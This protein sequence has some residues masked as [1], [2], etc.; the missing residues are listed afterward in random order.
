MSSTRSSDPI[1]V[2]SLPDGP[3]LEHLRAQ[4]RNLQRAV[5]AGD[6]DALAVLGTFDPGGVPAPDQRPGYPLTA[7]QLVVARSYGFSSWRRLRD[8]VQTIADYSR[9]PE[10]LQPE[11][12]PGDR[13]PDLAADPD[14]LLR[15][16]CLNYTRDDPRLLDAARR[17]LADRPGLAEANLYTAAAA[18][19]AAIARR[20]LAD[21]AGRRRVVNAPG[22]P[23]DWPPLLYLAYSRLGDGPDRSALDTASVLLAAGADPNAGYL[24]QAMTWPFTALTGAFGGEQRQPPHQHATELARLL[25]DAGADPNDSQALYNRM[26]APSNDHVELLFGYGLGTDVYS[27]WRARLGDSYPSPEQ[28]LGDQLCW[29]AQQ[30]MPERV[31][32][33]LAAGVAPDNR[34]QHPGFGGSTPYQLAVAA[35]HEAIAGM[36][37]TAGAN[38]G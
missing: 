19:A 23:F 28:M 11:S 32:L 2:R 24:W 12:G 33:L 5:R 4:A 27:P 17:L 10:P 8:R 38:P 21:A 1:H 35:G 36:L 20:L 14:T 15:A 31:R 29:A 37:L 9:W 34:G 16:G 3:N 6:A 13:L 25:L 26:F 7:A 30:G 18:G 22:G